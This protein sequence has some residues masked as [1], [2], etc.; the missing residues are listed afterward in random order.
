MPEWQDPQGV[1]ANV[2][3]HLVPNRL[4]GHF[5]KTFDRGGSGTPGFQNSWVPLKGG[6]H[7]VGAHMR[8]RIADLSPEEQENIRTYNREQKAKSRANQKAAAYIPTANEAADRFA[9]DFPEREKELSAYVKQFSN[10]VVEELGR[11]LGSPQ[12]DPLGNV[13]GWDHDEEF[14]VDR[15][16]RTLLALKKNWIQKVRHPEGDMVSGSYFADSFGS[17]VESAHRRGLKNSETFRLLYRELLEILDK[18]YG[19]QQTGDATIIRAELAG[20]YPTP[21]SQ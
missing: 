4:Y 8:K 13:V 6:P 11:K 10:K 12:K 18:R 17:V 21:G 3:V 7:A 16:A 20:E 9:I 2:N 19:R 14:T 5:V 15:V 1:F